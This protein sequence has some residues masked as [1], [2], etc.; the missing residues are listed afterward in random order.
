MFDVRGRKVSSV[1]QKPM[2]AGT[3]VV[4][5]D[6]TD[7]CGARLASGVYYIRLVADGVE[8]ARRVTLVR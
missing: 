3:H 2:D 7:D 1:V 5:W 6:G 8:T 4:S